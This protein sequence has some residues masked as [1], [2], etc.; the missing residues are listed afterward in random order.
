M[1]HFVQIKRADGTK[2]VHEFS[3]R[4]DRNIFV[5]GIAAM[6]RE[7]VKPAA[8]ARHECADQGRPDGRR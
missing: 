3:S 7:P 1:S 2:E 8:D 4:R 5:K 6:M